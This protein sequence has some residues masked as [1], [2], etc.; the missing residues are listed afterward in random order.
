MDIVTQTD[1]R[2]KNIILVIENINEINDTNEIKNSK[3]YA[4]I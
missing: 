2:N 3:K 1:L 4:S